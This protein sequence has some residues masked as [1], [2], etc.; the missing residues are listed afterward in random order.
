[1]NAEAGSYKFVSTA[2]SGDAATGSDPVTVG[3]L[4]GVYAT[5][6]VPAESY[7]LW[8]NSTNPIG[9]YKSNN[10]TVAAY[11][12]YLTADG[13]G[14]RVSISFVD[15]SETTGVAN[16]NINHNLNDNRY[17]NLNGQRI[18]KPARGLYIVGG[19]KVVIK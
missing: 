11:R 19:K 8:A 18:E 17:Y 6:D 3:A 2:A 12:A 1:V 7:I 13:A 10:S 15:D 14:A 4:T 9:F 5:T 16:L